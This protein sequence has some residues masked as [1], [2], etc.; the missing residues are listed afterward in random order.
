MI[1]NSRGELA[2]IELTRL[3]ASELHIKFGRNERV[4]ILNHYVLAKL[5]GSL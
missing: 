3:L 5:G 1:K 4:V 2:T